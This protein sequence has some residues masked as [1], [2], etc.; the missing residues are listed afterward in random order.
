MKSFLFKLTPIIAIILGTWFGVNYLTKPSEKEKKKSAHKK[1]NN[2]KKKH[3]QQ[4][5]QKT[6]A[7]T[8]TPIDYTVKL[9]TQ[10]TVK[11][12][13]STTLNPL[14]PGKVISISDKFQDGAFFK[15]GTIL[16]QLDTTDFQS[17]IITSN[18]S[19]ARAEAA[20]IQEKARAAQALRN[21]KDIGFDEAPND[22]VLRKPQLRQAEANLA[23]QQASLDKAKR[24]LARASIKA[25]FNGR[26]R[27]RI[28]GPGQSVGASTN[29]GEIYATDYAEIRLPLSSRQLEQITINEQGNQSI[30]VTLT[31]AINSNN[32]TIWKANIKHVEGELDEASRELFVIAEIADP[33]GILTN[34]P[35]LRINK[36]VKASIKGNTL[37]GAFVIDRKH[38]YGANEI[39]LI[40]NNKIKR[41]KINIVWSTQDTIIT[42]DPELKNK[43]LATSRL[44]FATNGSK[45]EIIPP[46]ETEADQPTHAKKKK[47]TRSERRKRRVKNNSPKKR[48]LKRPSPNKT[49]SK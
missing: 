47:D 2:K 14:V 29:L 38:L 11:T 41:Q 18:A 48:N 31:D 36:P 23:A 43:T 25:P 9:I 22:L 34:S 27:K 26:V 35:P 16:V 5:G 30:P 20:L 12:K 39:I 45:V 21:W 44:V 13:T 32:Q 17:Q 42:Q 4:R 28:V 1:Q 15:K 46:E 8:L 24:T 49:T 3:R 6:Y 10:G 7:T 33:F 37:K 40:E 19:L